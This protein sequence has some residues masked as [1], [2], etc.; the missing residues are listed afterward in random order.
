MLPLAPE[1]KY[2]NP[3]GVADLARDV[4]YLTEF[5][6]SLDN[7]FMLEQNL[8]ELKQSVALMQTENADEFYDITTRNKK[9][10]RVNAQNGAI[11]LEKV[12]HAVEGPNR[13]AQALGNFSSRFGLR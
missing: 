13:A 12:T 11:L 8:D 9:F 4:Q 7:A 1:V 3:N 2:I 5:V 10:G 6:G